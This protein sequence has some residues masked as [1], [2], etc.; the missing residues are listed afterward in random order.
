[1]QP[2]N[3]DEYHR[4][5]EPEYKYKQNNKQ[6]APDNNPAARGHIQQILLKHS[7]YFNVNCV[8]VTF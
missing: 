2:Q 8:S 1:M 7:E 6:E 4:P 5:Q 3:K